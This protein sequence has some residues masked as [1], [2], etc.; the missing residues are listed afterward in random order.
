M[1]RLAAER[2]TSVPN[3]RGG[4][5]EMVAAVRFSINPVWTLYTILQPPRAAN[6]GRIKVRM[7][8]LFH[9]AI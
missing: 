5:G 4:W 2:T 6:A 8:E 9:I 7:R 1:G 3:A